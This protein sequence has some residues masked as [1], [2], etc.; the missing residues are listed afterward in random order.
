MEEVELS[1]S[2]VVAL[3]SSEDDEDED[4]GIV[5]ESRVRAT[6]EVAEVHEVALLQRTASARELVKELSIGNSEEVQ[7]E[8]RRLSELEASLH[9]A[10]EKVV[11]HQDENNDFVQLKNCQSIE[12]AIDFLTARGRNATFR[13]QPL[14]HVN[15]TNKHVLS[16]ASEA[17]ARKDIERDA[18]V[19]SSD[20]SRVAVNHAEAYEAVLNQLTKAAAKLVKKADATE[21]RYADTEDFRRLAKCALRAVNRTESGGLGLETLTNIL[22]TCLAPVPDSKNAEPLHIDLSLGPACLDH[23]RY[24]WRWG[25]RARVTGTTLYRLF[26]TDSDFLES[27]PIALARATY[28]NFLL[29]PLDALDISQSETSVL[30]DCRRASILVNLHLTD[31]SLS[32][33]EKQSSSSLNNPSSSFTKAIVRPS[34]FLEQR[35]RSSHILEDV[36]KKK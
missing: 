33:S 34:S 6:R 26:P 21:W 19:V 15:T 29:L 5:L 17:Q 8:A 30:F 10:W 18:L 14:K 7:D 28:T 31:D 13:L 3:P 32:V 1:L 35:R 12:D 2:E 36:K 27:G 20:G 11:L 9:V 23:A 22:P 25:L 16:D 24:R 4:A